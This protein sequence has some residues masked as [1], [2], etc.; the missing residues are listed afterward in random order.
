MLEY[1]VL[2]VAPLKAPSDPHSGYATQKHRFRRS[3]V[4]T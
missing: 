2:N 4:R 3:L 1:S